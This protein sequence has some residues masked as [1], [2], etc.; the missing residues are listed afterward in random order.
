M[1]LQLEYIY[2][3]IFQ[4]RFQLFFRK[5]L[6]LNLFM[7]LLSQLWCYFSMIDPFTFLEKLEKITELLSQYNRP[8]LFHVFLLFQI[9]IILKV[10]QVHSTGLVSLRIKLLQN[11]MGIQVFYE[12]FSLTLVIRQAAGRIVEPVFHSCPVGIKVD[13]GG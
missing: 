11:K 13:V 2:Y 1:P 3:Y 12:Q 9:K 7:L 6:L 10:L 5:S 8:H 4:E